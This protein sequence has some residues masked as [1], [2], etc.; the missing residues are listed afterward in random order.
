MPLIIGGKEIRTGDTGRIGDAARSQPRARRLSQGHRAARRAG[1]RGGA[2][3]RARNGRSWS[4]DDRA[5]V[6]LKAAELL[7][8]SWRDTHQRRD[9]ARPVEDGVPGRDRRGRARS[10]T[11]GASTSTTARNCSTS[12]RSAT[13]R[14]GTSSS[15]A[16]SRGS[17]TPSRRSTSPRSAANLPTAPALMGNTVVWKPASSA[18]FSALLPD[19]AVRSGRHAARRHQLRRRR[20][21]DDLEGAALAPRSRRRPLH[22]QHRGLQRHVEDDRRLDVRLPLLPA[23]RRRNRR[24]GLHRRAPVG[25]RRRRWRW[26]SC[27]AASSS[28][29]RSARPRAASTSRDR[30]GTTSATARSR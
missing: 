5:A 29:A 22:R 6:L 2:R 8:T 10:S 7:T 13:T 20:R 19:E 9:D 4:F 11:S 17:S 12:S 23:H 30:C 25:R 26:R 28:R 15:T 18:M 14:C 3:R 16:A 21:G 1:G 27:A 24:Q